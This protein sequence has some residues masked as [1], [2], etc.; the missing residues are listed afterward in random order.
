LPH[1]RA[2]M[3]QVPLPFVNDMEETL[4]DTRRL[5]APRACSVTVQCTGLCI[6]C[7]LLGRRGGTP[8][9]L[10]ILLRSVFY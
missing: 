7:F 8:R 9:F 4:E 10:N 5:G 6:A 1:Q 3:D 2:N